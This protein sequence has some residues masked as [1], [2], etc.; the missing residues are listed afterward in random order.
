MIK[1]KPQCERTYWKG[2][3]ACVLKNGLIQLTHLVHGGQIVDLHF[4]HAPSTNPFWIPQWKIREPGQF[5]PARDGRTFGSPESGK[6]LSCIAGHTLCLDLFGPPS[7]DEVRLG[8]VLHGEAGVSAWKASF[9][10]KANERVLRFSV[11]LPAAALFFRRD[12]TLRADES[13]V[14]IRETVQNE[15]RV[16]QFIQWQQHATLG[17]PFLG[18]DSCIVELSGARSITHPSGYEGA[19][20][21]A[22]GAEFMW[23]FA[24]RLDGNRTDLRRVLITEGKGFVV[25]VQVP[26]NRKYGFVCAIDTRSSVAFGY[27]F[28]RTDFP[29]IVLWEENR[30]RC[31]PPWD[32]REQTRGLEF[33]TSALPR[34]RDE[35]YHDG[36]IFG[37]PTLMR[38]P[39]K[40]S[41]TVSY[42]M[43]L[44]QVPEGT[45]SVSDICVSRESLDLINSA[46]KVCCSLPVTQ[47]D[48]IF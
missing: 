12:L 26:P 23:P 25:G 29:W 45:D 18:Y 13:V 48:E 9:V 35:T 5:R 3:A 34:T 2:R 38:I 8:A 11:H 40:G 42:V 7:T 32:R 37:A 46:G 16:D 22:S 28:P 36:A 30:A 39:A 43:F 24:P 27:C 41:R 21:L 10:K 14:A 19:E 31:A 1:S 33:G 17:P 15:R 4:C 44:G 47:S 6:L 20:L